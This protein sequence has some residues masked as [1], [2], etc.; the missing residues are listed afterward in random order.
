MDALL[1]SI[2]SELADQYG[3]KAWVKNQEV[4]LN[5][6]KDENTKTTL[7]VLYML[8]LT[9]SIL[10]QLSCQTHYFDDMEN[11]RLKELD[12]LMMNLIPKYCLSRNWASIV[13][14]VGLE[15]IAWSKHFLP[16]K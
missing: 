3:F 11:S 14:P 1:V 16:G 8:Q 10:Y 15:E 6:L 12:S 4:L 5:I 9:T 7:S 13:E 2:G